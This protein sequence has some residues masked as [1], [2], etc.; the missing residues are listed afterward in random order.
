MGTWVLLAQTQTGRHWSDFFFSLSSGAQFVV[1][2][3]AIGCFTGIITSLITAISSTMTS[4]QL[5]KFGFELKRELVDRGMTAEEIAQVVE[6]TPADRL[7][8]KH[9]KKA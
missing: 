1:V 7:P 2:I 9:R 3:V 5:A 4:S 8:R 6:A